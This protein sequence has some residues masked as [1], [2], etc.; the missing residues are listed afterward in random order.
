MIVAFD[1]VTLVDIVGPADVFNL[2]SQF[3]LPA[4]SRRYRLTL[5]SIAG[6]PIVAS[7]G[8]VV[9]TVPISEVD[10]SSVGTLMVPGSGPPDNP[11]VPKDIVDW[12]RTHALGP[13]RVCAVCTGIFLLAAA[14]HTEG[15]S[16]TTHWQAVDVLQ[17]RY[18]SMRVTADAVYIKDGK[19]WSSAG[20]STGIDLA[21]ALITEDHGHD[22]ALDVAK[23]LVLFVKRPSDQPQI[24]TPLKLQSL[25][26]AQ[27]SALHA[28]IANNLD[29]KLTIGALADF[30]G[31]PSA[32]QMGQ[33][34]RFSKGGSAPSGLKVRLPAGGA[35]SGGWRLSC[36]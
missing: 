4:D 31:C 17:R 33:A 16:V 35:A 12:L 2:A 8:I 29:K 19:V 25:S 13:S 24:S 36:A 28:W 18:P 3:A 21:L 34:G 27:F 32:G 10:F 6:G 5:A 30:A 22:A 26:N 15:K 1:G 14:G 7:N 11:P 20:F 23:S 9:H